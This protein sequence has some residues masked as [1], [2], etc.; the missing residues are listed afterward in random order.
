MSRRTIELDDRL[1][2]YL[3]KVGLRDDPILARLREETG[4]LP[5]GGMQISP[6]QGQFMGLLVELLGARRALE[7]GTFTGYSALCVARAL[8]ADGRLIA[9]DVS[10]EWTSIAR[11]YWAEAG[12]DDRIDLRL[13]PARASL[14]ALLE[15]GAGTFDFAFIDADKTAYDDYYERTLELL[16]PGGLVA[17]DN[18]LQHGAVADPTHT[19]DSVVAIRALN[20]KLLG[21]ARVTLSLLP[22]GDGLSLA[23]KR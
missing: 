22:V 7:V 5:N 19:S 17:F 15:D 23:R 13:G 8:P 6:E 4:A 16:R 21:D 14:D 10:E 3:L 11:R 20:E 1:Y 12:V 9:C 2:A 18:M